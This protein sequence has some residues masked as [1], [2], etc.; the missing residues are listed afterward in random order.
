MKLFSDRTDI[1]YFLRLSLQDFAEKLEE[2]LRK[3]KRQGQGAP[4]ARAVIGEMLDDAWDKFWNSADAK[5]IPMTDA[6]RVLLDSL[7]EQILNSFNGYCL[8]TPPAF[9]QSSEE[10]I[11]WVTEDV[12]SQ[13]VYWPIMRRRLERKYAPA[14]VDSIDEQSERVLRRLHDPKDHSHWQTRGL[15]VG[16]V[17]SGKTANYSAVIA[18]AADAGYR[19]IIVLS[20]IHNDLRQQTQARLDEEFVG[21]HQEKNGSDVKKEYCGVS[22]DPEWNEENSPQSATY[23]N[24]DFASCSV[25]VETRPWLFVIK[26]NSAVFK[27]LVNWIKNRV[28]NRETRPLLL[29]DDEADQAS[30]NTNQ[31]EEQVTA[32][33]GFIRKILKLFPRASFIG[34][35]ATPFANVFISRRAESK[36]LGEDLFPKDFILP[37]PAPVK[38]FGPRQFFSDED[39]GGLDL[40]MPIPDESAQS[41]IVRGRAAGKRQSRLTV[42]DDVPA[43]AVHALYQFLL[44]TAIRLWRWERRY[45]GK[46]K[47]DENGRFITTVMSSMLVHV[48]HRVSQ[49]KKVAVQYRD[50]LVGVRSSLYLGGI[51][52]SRLRSEFEAFFDNQCKVVTP[53]IRRCRSRTDSESD[54]SLPASFDELAPLIDQVI[55]DTEIRLVNGEADP[56]VFEAAMPESRNRPRT[57][58]CIYVGG[59]KLSRG[60]TLPGLCMSLFLRTSNM[61]D[62]LLQMGRWF[63]YR[64]GYADLCRISTTMGIFEWFQAINEAFHDFELQLH[65]MN[66]KERTPENYRLHVLSHPGLLIIARNKMRNTDMSELNFT[67]QTQDSRFLKL[68]DGR[69]GAASYRRRVLE[70]A[71]RFYKSVCSDGE[72]VYWDPSHDAH[73]PGRRAEDCVNFMSNRGCPEGRLWRNVPTADVIRFLTEFDPMGVPNPSRKALRKQLEEME[74]NEELVD[75]TVFIPGKAGETEFRLEPVERSLKADSFLNE[76]TIRALRTGG[77]QYVGISKELVSAVQHAAGDNSEPGRRFKMLRKMAGDSSVP[78]ASPSTGHLILYLV[79]SKRHDMK[80]GDPGSR[81]CPIAA[82]DLWLPD[83]PKHH[84]MS[85]AAFNAT[86]A[87]IDQEDDEYDAD[88]AAEEH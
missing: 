67:G 38:Y 6:E 10:E 66:E 2:D 29:I 47:I 18:K 17:Q 45:G 9:V 70:P 71:L 57:K 59:N 61:Y 25:S 83:S 1:S 23:L 28:P 79:K 14:D 44:S 27:K 21:F 37:L 85:V 51:A 36:T 43:E 46:E 64:D 49:Q 56:E 52:R 63:G 81:T 33:N 35:T 32:T 13:R 74:Q 20:G 54:W 42:S 88:A 40:F 12:R 69:S 16:Q 53:E 82:Y 4:L 55:E 39:D 30:I 50:L 86:V 24:C 80:D 75:W 7:K 48:S 22:D 31:S 65:D 3:R 60:L 8:V 58:T 78:G 76:V 68:R 77:H 19:V 11:S 72:L 34:Y 73:C 87:D 84:G 41:W 62:T 15:V 26:K 5:A